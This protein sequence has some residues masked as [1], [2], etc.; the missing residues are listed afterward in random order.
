MYKVKYYKKS[1]KKTILYHSTYM[2]YSESKNQKWNKTVV[3][4]TRKRGRQELL[5]DAHIGAA[6]QVEESWRQ[7]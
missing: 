3:A 1:T 7:C 6:L 5:F 2:R 4:R